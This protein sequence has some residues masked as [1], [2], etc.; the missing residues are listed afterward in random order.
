VP[1]R[2][3]RVSIS[4]AWHCGRCTGKPIVDC[5][6]YGFAIRFCTWKPGVAIEMHDGDLLASALPKPRILLVEDE[7]ALR[8]HLAPGAVR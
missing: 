5:P 2:G 1:R 7:A 4:T 3:R 6:G 8:E